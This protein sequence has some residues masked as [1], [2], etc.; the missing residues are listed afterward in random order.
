MG[1]V[2]IKVVCSQD[3]FE[4]AIGD[5]LLTKACYLRE[6]N[7]LGREKEHWCE[8]APILVNDDNINAIFNLKC[9]W[10]LI[11]Q[12]LLNIPLFDAI[13]L[14]RLRIVLNPKVTDF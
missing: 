6:Q 11:R 8:I 7:L 14:E 5:V 9:H 1:L 4:W 12:I 13:K 10:V 2:G 3:R